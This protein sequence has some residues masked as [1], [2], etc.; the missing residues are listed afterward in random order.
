MFQPGDGDLH[1][2]RVLTNLSIAYRNEMY[3]AQQIFPVV[4]VNNRSDIIPRYDKSHWFRDEAKK[5]A[6]MEAP[7]VGGYTVDV[8]MKYFC[9]EYGIGHVI[10]DTVRANAD[11][12]FQP[13]RDGMEWVVDRIDMRRERAFLADFWKTGVWTTDKVGSTDFTK[14]SLY[15]TSNPIV[16]VRNWKRTMRRL[17]MREANT[18][19]LGDMVH[20][21]LADHPAILDRIKFGAS[22]SAPAMVETNLLAQLWGIGKVLVG[23]S[24]YTTSP[25]GTAEASVSYTANWD[26]DAL[27]LYQPANPSL[28][29]PAAGYNFVWRTVW[30]GQRY[31]RRRREPL[32]EK[33]DL[34]EAFEYFDMKQTAAD[35]GM[36]ISDAVDEP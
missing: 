4:P 18:M 19:V 20:D 26:D 11:S 27:L 28:R 12:P 16:D 29:T 7:P 23:T 36:F 33:G 25:E 31:I 17:I 15:A 30:G 21:V 14:W 34:I 22:S 5:L 9:D 2:D 32:S 3:I 8:T 1:V 10:P 13:D 24:V 6:P 35:A